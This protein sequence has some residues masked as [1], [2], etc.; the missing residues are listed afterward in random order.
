MYINYLPPS[1]VVYISLF[2]RELL[3]LRCPTLC[4]R[5]LWETGYTG[6]ADHNPLPWRQTPRQRSLL[7]PMTSFSNSS[8]NRKQRTDADDQSEPTMTP[9]WTRCTATTQRL[10]QR[11]RTSWARGRRCLMFELGQG[12]G[13]MWETCL[14]M[15][16]QRLA[17]GQHDLIATA[18]NN[19]VTKP[20]LSPAAA[21]TINNRS[22]LQTRLT[23][24][25]WGRERGSPSRVST[26]RMTPRMLP[27]TRSTRWRHYSGPHA[28]TPSRLYTIYTTWTQPVEWEEESSSSLR[29]GTARSVIRPY[30]SQVK[31]YLMRLVLNKHLQS[32]CKKYFPQGSKNGFKFRSIDG[33]WRGYGG[34]RKPLS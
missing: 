21:T 17:R 19:K 26:V 20:R 28:V 1:K 16:F 27:R 25:S 10:H 9:T 23:L 14:A 24:R 30:M 3:E 6:D 5:L 34:N 33:T 13:T 12:A 4:L 29:A 2:H 22:T 7:H 8:N 11:H 18:C 15:T 32:Y 31:T